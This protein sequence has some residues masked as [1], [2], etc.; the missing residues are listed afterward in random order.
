MVLEHLRQR[1]RTTHT[2]TNRRTGF[3]RMHVLV[4]FVGIGDTRAVEG[5]EYHS[6]QRTTQRRSDVVAL[7]GSNRGSK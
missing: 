7:C 5:L 1:L 4:E 3:G 2:A 6:D